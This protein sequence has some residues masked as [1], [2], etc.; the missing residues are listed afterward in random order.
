MLAKH[1]QER[2]RQRQMQE[3]RRIQET[4]AR[5]E[6][7]NKGL[8]GLFDRITGAYSR[9]KKQNEMEN[10]EAHRRHQ[11]QRDALIFRQI[12]QKRELT[13]QQ[14]QA[15]QKRENLRTQL[16]TDLDRLEALRSRSPSPQNK[17]HE[18]EL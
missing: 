14:E 9:T 3:Q 11:Q 1:T 10:Y 15:R 5:Q 16:R 7:F 4:Q 17:G 12:D 2:Q 6:R 18:R 13:Q 8:R